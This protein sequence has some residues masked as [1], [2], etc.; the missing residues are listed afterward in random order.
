M[1][2]YYELGKETVT[3]INDLHIYLKK[4]IPVA[5]YLY[6]DDLSILN[7]MKYREAL[8]YKIKLS[9][10]LITKLYDVSWMYRDN[11]RITKTINSQN[12]NQRLIDE[13][14]KKR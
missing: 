7:N 1:F 9:L 10:K 14:P 5:Q 8:E 11:N 2:I 4:H 3:N 6:D 12:F 13:L